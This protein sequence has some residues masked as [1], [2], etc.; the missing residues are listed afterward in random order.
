M[1]KYGTDRTLFQGGNEVFQMPSNEMILSAASR[2]AFL[3]AEGETGI[4]CGCV[5]VE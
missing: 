4:N 5:L 3:P 2:A 1:D